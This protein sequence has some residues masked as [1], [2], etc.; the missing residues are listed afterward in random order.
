MIRKGGGEAKK[1]K[2]PGRVINVMLERGQTWGE[3]ESM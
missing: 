3:E 1:R 2:K